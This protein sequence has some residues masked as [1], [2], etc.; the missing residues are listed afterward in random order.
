MIEELHMFPSDHKFYL[1]YRKGLVSKIFSRIRAMRSCSVVGASGMGK[2]R[3]FDYMFKEDIREHYLKEK[4]EN[5]LFVR[6]DCNLRPGDPEIPFSV[7]MLSALIQALEKHSDPDLNK[8]AVRYTYDL[9]HP[10]K[11]SA[12]S[13]TAL[14]SLKAAL[15][16][17]YE[18]EELS[19]CFF[20]DEFGGRYSQLPVAELDNLRGLRDANKKNICYVALFRVAPQYLRDVSEVENIYEIITSRVYGLTTYND[21]DTDLMFTELE[22]DF[23]IPLLPEN[24]KR[25]YTESGGH[26]GTMLAL[27]ETVIEEQSIF[28]S[29]EETKKLFSSI[30]KEEIRKLWDSLPKREQ[31]AFEQIIDG[32]RPEEEFLEQLILKG[33]ASESNS[34][35]KTTLPL[36][37][38]YVSR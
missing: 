12:D 35:V 33:L 18:N 20:L 21:I 11:E 8:R 27:F 6:V 23:G 32:N 37:E 24:K 3:L 13:F 19:V 1:Q 4:N 5:C 22:N 7:L 16:P 30:K 36:L 28:T 31:E 38:G 34:V 25:I 29:D 26:P 14:R 2:T 17:L 10:L 9:L 15:E